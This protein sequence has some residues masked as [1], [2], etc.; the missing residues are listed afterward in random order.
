[1]TR[2]LRIAAIAAHTPDDR[3][4]NAEFGAQRSFTGENRLTK[5]KPAYRRKAPYT[6]YSPR[7]GSVSLAVYYSVGDRVVQSQYQHGTVSSVNEYHTRIDFDE[8]GTRTFLT[9]R[10]QLAPSDVPA[11]VKVK[12]T[13]AKSVKKAA[14]PA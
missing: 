5:E 8:H 10:V 12:R 4:R 9:S 3:T 6:G 11:P 2:L 1:M 7:K 13:R 14:A